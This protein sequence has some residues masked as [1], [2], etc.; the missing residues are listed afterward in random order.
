MVAFT[1]LIS[2]ATGILFG[3]IPALPASRANRFGA[4]FRQQ[5]IR[6]LLVA[7]EMA[8]GARAADRIGTADP[9][10][11][12]D[13]AVDLGFDTHNVLTMEI[14]L[15]DEKY[16]K[17]AA[18]SELARSSIERIRAIPGVE[19]AAA[20]CCM[21]LGSVPIAPFVIAGRAVN[22]T[23]HGRAGAPTV[24]PDYFNV[25]KIPILRGRMFTERDRAG[26][27]AVAIISQALAKQF[28]PNTDPIG[29][30]I[31][32]GRTTQSN[33]VLMEVVGIA[34]DVHDRTER[35]SDPFFS[36]DLHSVGA[37]SATTTPPIWFVFLRCG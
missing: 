34:R 4:K 24:S 13:R 37:E 36:D 8:S 29:Q 31:S 14:S 28:W 22:G 11:P 15:S 18:L 20:G 9:H 5:R 35:A 30:K 12:C 17:T 2:I 25:F 32:L 33:S 3:L 10:F 19:Y 6:S 23:F 1:A 26:A 7:A 16:Q 21:P 27:P